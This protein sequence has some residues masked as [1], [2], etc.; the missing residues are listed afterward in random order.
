[1]DLEDKKYYLFG[2]TVFLIHVAYVAIFFGVL[3]IDET[4]L[5]KLSILVQFIVCI[6]LM[7]RFFPLRQINT[8]T[9][10]DRSI[11]FYSATFLFMNVVAIEIYNTFLTPL[12]GW[13]L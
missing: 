1:M 5:H 13:L 4:Y 12:R 2:G 10:F 11:I 3:Y 8:L 6:I 7:Y 9:R